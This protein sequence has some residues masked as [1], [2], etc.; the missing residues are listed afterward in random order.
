MWKSCGYF[1]KL[2][3]LAEISSICINSSQNLNFLEGLTYSK[4]C[5]ID[6]ITATLMNIFLRLSVS[7][8]VVQVSSLKEEA[9]VTLP[10]SLPVSLQEEGELRWAAEL[11]CLTDQTLT[12]L[13][14]QWDRPEFPP[15]VLLELVCLVVQGLS[16]MQPGT[17]S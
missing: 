2:Q 6:L 4:C 8:L 15:E 9:Q 1:V 10:E 14:D 5:Y 11:L 13:R 16:L 7:C 3:A 17:H 12:E